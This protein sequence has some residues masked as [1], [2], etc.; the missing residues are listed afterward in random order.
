[1]LILT[2]DKE[3]RLHTFAFVNDTK[4][5]NNKQVNYYVSIV[6]IVFVNVR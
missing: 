6:S 2:L 3:Y 1:M 5:N 4:R